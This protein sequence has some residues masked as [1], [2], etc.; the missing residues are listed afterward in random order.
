MG[1]KLIHGQGPFMLVVVVVVSHISSFLIST[2]VPLVTKSKAPREHCEKKSRAPTNAPQTPSAAPRSVHFYVGKD[3]GRKQNK[4]KRFERKRGVPS[5]P[6]NY[7]ERLKCRVCTG[8]VYVHELLY[9]PGCDVKQRYKVG[10]LR[11][12]TVHVSSSVLL[13]WRHCSGVAR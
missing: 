8:Q 9:S 11:G 5:P 4:I 3:P 10:T 7:A 12:S 2:I 13:N 6:F 1:Y